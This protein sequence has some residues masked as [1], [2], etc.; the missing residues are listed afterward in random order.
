MANSGFQTWTKVDDVE[1]D[2]SERR[3]PALDKRLG[4]EQ[5]GFTFAPPW[6]HPSRL[7]VVTTPEGVTH[8]YG[9]RD[10][11][12]MMDDLQARYPS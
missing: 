2:R 9:G 6:E 1:A 8:E 11:D 10:A 12:L 4:W 5:R 3:V 7:W